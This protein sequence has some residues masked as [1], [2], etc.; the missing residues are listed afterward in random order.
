[1]DPSVSV[2]N[3]ELHEY[4]TLQYSTLNANTLRLAF[5]FSGVTA[6][7]KSVIFCMYMHKRSLPSLFFCSQ[8]NIAVSLTIRFFTSFS[9]IAVSVG[10]VVGGGW[11]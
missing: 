8:G 7:R 10:G 11:G 6:E 5:S 1:M 2:T 4:S 9:V 3:T